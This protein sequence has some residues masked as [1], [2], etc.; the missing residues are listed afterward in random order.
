MGAIVT[1]PLEVVKTRLQS[2][3]FVTMV[4]LPP[5]ATMCGSAATCS[6]LPYPRSSSSSSR[7]LSTTSGANRSQVVHLSH[8]FPGSDPPRNNV[9][10][11]MSLFHCLK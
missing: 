10:K 8:Q 6:T 1:C 7:K 2:S 9:P 11:T 5:P 4:S 3:T